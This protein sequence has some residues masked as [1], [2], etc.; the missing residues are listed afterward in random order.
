MIRALHFHSRGGW[1]SIPGLETKILHAA[2]CSQRGKKKL[3][4]K[5]I[6][7]RPFEDKT[8]VQLIG[9]FQSSTESYVSSSSLMF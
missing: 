6:H 8:R 3:S 2:W 5:L 4:H 7:L 1:V 9:Y